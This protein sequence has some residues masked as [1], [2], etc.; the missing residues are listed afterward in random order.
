MQY[1]KSIFTYI[2][3]N[4]LLVA[5][6]ILILLL[7]SSLFYQSESM[8]KQ[9]DLKIQFIEQKNIIRDELDDLVD[10]HDELLEEYGD[11]NNQLFEKDSLI[12]NQI[13]EIKNL[14]R[15]KK[16][17]K[18]ARIKIENL[19]RIS[20]RY[21][22]DI[23]SLFYINERLASEKDS[24]IKVNKNINWKNYTLNKKNI[25]LSDQ[26]NKGSVL[27]V[28][29]ISVEALRFRGTGKE[30]PTRS[31]QKTQILRSCFNISANQI[32]KSGQK[33]LCIQYLNPRGEILNSTDSVNINQVQYSFTDS[34]NYLNKDLEIC[35][36]FERNKMLIEG[37]YVLKV[38]IDDL[39]LAESKF[40][41]R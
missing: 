22:A 16:D 32:A 19:K 5:L 20:K 18:E 28:S 7:I 8:K 24:V 21:L 41:L 34:I 38:F 12:Q 3:N 11:L 39:F 1:F 15:N 10:E 33:S 40:N 13:A 25:Q 9:M 26:V 14:I 31:A 36:D 35:I 4:K 17:L 30:V 6:F 29:N 2:K 37:N 23:D 27:E